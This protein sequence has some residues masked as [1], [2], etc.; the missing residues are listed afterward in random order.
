[1]DILAMGTAQRRTIDAMVKEAGGCWIHDGFEEAVVCLAIGGS[2][3]GM[4]WIVCPWDDDAAPSG[5]DVD[6]RDW[7]ASIFFVDWDQ[8]DMGGIV[9]NGSYAECVEALKNYDNIYSETGHRIRSA[10]GERIDGW[11]HGCDH[12]KP[13]NL[14]HV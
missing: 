4:A 6:L 3:E 8:G 9:F 5:K 14:I 11:W 10:T 12:A 7:D 1:M 13:E 2:G